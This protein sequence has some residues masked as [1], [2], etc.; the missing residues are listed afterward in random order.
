M[1]PA[2]ASLP[3]EQKLEHLLKQLAGL[4]GAVVAFSGGVDSTALLH[5]CHAALGDRVV[6]VTADSPSL[7][8]AEL[9]EAQSLAVDI[10]ARHVVLP[11]DELARA[12]YRKNAGDR[13]YHCKKELFVK[14]AERR[15]SIA[16]SDWAVVYGAI[17]DD[18][19]DHRPGQVA[20]AEH[21]VL[22]PLIDSGM[23][24]DDVRRYSRE[25]GLNTAEKPSFACLSS[26]VPYG[27]AIDRELLAKIESAEAILRAHGFRQ[28]RVRHHGDLARIE[29]APEEIER[30]FQMREALGRNV[31]AVGYKFVALDAFGYRSGAMNVLLEQVDKD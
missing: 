12:G 6:A 25:V 20:A 23:G 18:L 4:P 15:S 5:A 28:F 30:A 7:P 29:V 26:R 17:T 2:T 10:G 9:E 31:Q 27:I 11:T 13:C 24:K 19:G 8:R 14:V 21:A 3:Y 16:P 1:L 22:A